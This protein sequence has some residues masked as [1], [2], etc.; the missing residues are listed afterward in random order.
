VNWFS[1]AV[2]AWICFGFELGLRDT[3]QLGPHAIAPS[4]VV[5]LLIFIALHASQRAAIWAAII[6]GV[7]IDLTGSIELVPSG[8][9]VLVGP[10]AIAFVLATQMVLAMRGM[11]V[12]RNPLSMGVL[13]LFAAAIAQIVVVAFLTYHKIIADPIVWNASERLLVGLA[14]AVYTGVLA[15]LLALVLIPVTPLF[16]FATPRRFG[17]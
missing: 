10:H 17:H 13:A 5:A 8:S 1:F 2:A 14:S 7:L 6:L 12:S 3:L 11:I 15:V 9:T 16:G 4:F